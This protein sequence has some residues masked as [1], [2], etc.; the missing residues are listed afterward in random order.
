MRDD[1]DVYTN[2][3]RSLHAIAEHVLSAALHAATGRIGLRAIPGGFGTPWYPK[4]DGRRR[5]RIDGI[6]LVVEDDERERRAPLMT[7]RAAAE[8]VGVK[9]GAPADVYEPTTPLELDRPLAIDASATRL[10][11]DWYALTDAA[12]SQLRDELRHDDP[13]PVQLWPEHLDLATTIG[14]VNYGGSP[15]DDAHPGPYLYV[16]PFRPPTPDGGFWN[17]PFGSSIGAAEIADPDAAS[18]YFRSGRERLDRLGSAKD[19]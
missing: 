8:L 5:V 9:P 7:I 11:A 4:A 1:D 6:T 12:L 3:R 10:V 14:E 15:G 18:A 16:G 17:E 2:T 19:A 13:A